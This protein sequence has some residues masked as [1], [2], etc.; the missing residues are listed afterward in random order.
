MKNKVM[1][2]S[3]NGNLIKEV[4]D[5]N[6]KLMGRDI[7]FGEKGRIASALFIS[8]IKMSSTLPAE[9]MEEM[10]DIEVYVFDQMIF[11]GKGSYF[12]GGGH[13]SPSITAEIENELFLIKPEGA[14]Y[15]EMTI[16]FNC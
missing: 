7:N 1:L 13:S 10:E 14:L 16:I 5:D 3:S 6:L 15:K 8:F 9:D 11:K 4:S 2:F 12:N